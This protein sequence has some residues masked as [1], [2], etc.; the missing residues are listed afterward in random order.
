MKKTSLAFIPLAMV[1]ATQAVF[2]QEGTP[3]PAQITTPEQVETPDG[4]LQFPKGVPTQEAA[5]KVY[6]H[7]DFLRGI[8]TYLNGHPAVSTYTI[9]KGFRDAGVK[10][11]DVLIFS[12]DRKLLW[13]YAARSSGGLGLNSEGT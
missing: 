8:N 13:G 11:G 4:A 10:D 12:R 5:D 2:A 6:D 1:L 9:R 7:L 3:V